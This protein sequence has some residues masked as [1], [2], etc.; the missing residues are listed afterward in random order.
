MKM[1][2][3]KQNSNYGGYSETPILGQE[4]LK[5]H[6]NINNPISALNVCESASYRTL[7]S[8]YTMVTLDLDRK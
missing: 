3:L 5:T 2:L 4:I 1:S 6:A 8:R 7:G